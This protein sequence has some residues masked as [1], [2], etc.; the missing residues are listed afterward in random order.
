MGHDKTGSAESG[1]NTGVSWS[2]RIFDL[3]SSGILRRIYGRHIS[4]C[5]KIVGVAIVLTIIILASCT[6]VS[7]KPEYI[8]CIE[9]RTQTSIISGETVASVPDNPSIVICPE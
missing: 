3:G 7:I 4:S 2:R 8:R 5:W 9:T 6:R 1:D